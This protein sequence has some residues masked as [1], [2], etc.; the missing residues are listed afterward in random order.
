RG[1]IASF[2]LGEL[3][4]KGA[5]GPQQPFVASGR[6]NQLDANWKAIRVRQKRQIE[7][8]ES[9]KGPKRAEDRIARRLETQRS[10]ALGGRRDDRVRNLL[11]D[12][13]HAIGIALRVA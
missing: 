11:E 6:S 10:D 7:G 2:C 5:R 1:H 13:S 8:G 9:D 3:F 12:A 4:D